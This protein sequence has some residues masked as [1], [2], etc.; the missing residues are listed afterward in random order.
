MQI[1]MKSNIF[2]ILVSKHSEFNLKK[3]GVTIWSL[4]LSQWTRTAEV[5]ERYLICI[6]LITSYTTDQDM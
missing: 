2:H 5:K 4:H 1:M 3:R 6:I